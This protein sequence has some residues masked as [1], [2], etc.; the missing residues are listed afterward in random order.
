MAAVANLPFYST[1]YGEG[2]GYNEREGTYVDRH[3]QRSGRGLSERTEADTD[4]L[5]AV[6]ADD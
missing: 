6:L 2:F 1:S 5:G 4:S 3:R